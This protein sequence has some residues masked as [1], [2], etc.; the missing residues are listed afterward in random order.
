MA[1]LAGMAL[2][3]QAATAAPVTLTGEPV[4]YAF[5]A[6]KACCIDVAAVNLLNYLDRQPGFGKL[7][8]DGRSIEA[9]QAGFHRRWDPD[10]NKTA[11]TRFDLKNALAATF[12]ARDFAADIK[13][14]ETKDLSYDNLLK[15]WNAHDLVI[16]L[17]NEV[18]LGWGHALLLWGLEDDKTKPRLAAVDPNL[19]PNTHQRIEGRDTG[20]AGAVVWSNLTIGTDARQWPD[21]RIRLQAPDHTYKIGQDEWVYDGKTYNFRISEFVSVSNVRAIPEPTGL[22]L[23]VQALVIAGA[24][25][26]VARRR[27]GR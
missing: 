27:R 20:S 7:V 5:E 13:L 24:A 4:D 25:V 12:K 3:L 6:D 19:H 15:G 9:Q 2:C 16:L 14:T 18:D 23:T 10:G 26:S 11:G 17:A 21:W 22:M 1:L 8:P